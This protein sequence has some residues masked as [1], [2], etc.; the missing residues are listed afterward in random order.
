MLITATYFESFIPL[1]V[2]KYIYLQSIGQ[3]KAVVGRAV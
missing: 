2:K 1:A 3:L